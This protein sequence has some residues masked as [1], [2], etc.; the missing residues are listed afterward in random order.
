LLFLTS[1]FSNQSKNISFGLLKKA[2]KTKAKIF[3]LAFLIIQK[4]QKFISKGLEKILKAKRSKAKR[5]KFL[6]ALKKKKPSIRKKA[7]H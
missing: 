6:G 7:Q 4:N 1:N 2:I 3:F 5:C